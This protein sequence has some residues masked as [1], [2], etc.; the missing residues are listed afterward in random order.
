MRN[1][2]WLHRWSGTDG[3]LVLGFACAAAD[4]DADGFEDLLVGGRTDHGAGGNGVRVFSGATGGVLVE[5]PNLTS[6]DTNPPISLLAPG[7]LNGDGQDDFVVGTPFDFL[8]VNK[9]GAVRAFSGGG[10]RALPPSPYC[11]AGTNS[12]G[13]GA[14]IAASGTTSLAAN[15]FVLRVDGNP[16]NA[17]GRFV[18]ARKR[19][20]VPFG[21]GWRCVDGPR[22]D[23]EPERADATGSVRLAIDNRAPPAIGHLL[24]GS[25]WFFQWWYRD[26]FA[27]GNGCNASDGLAATFCR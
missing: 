2:E 19:T 23:F 18:M 21:D 1:G 13:A 25:S 22:V 26:P 10:C 16:P 14:R 6:G 11:R 4:L 17:L 7:D 5:V 27:S 20:E 24:P 8:D 15:N 3:D 12:V 9:T